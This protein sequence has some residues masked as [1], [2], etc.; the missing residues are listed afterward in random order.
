M[1]D[2]RPAGVPAGPRCVI[3]NPTAGGNRARL[4]RQTLG[5]LAGQPVLM[6]TQCAGDAR[7]LAAEAIASGYTTIVAAGGDGTVNEVVDGL[8]TLPERLHG[9]RFGILPLG[10][11]NVLALELGIPFDWAKAWQLILG[12]SERPIDV[13]RA[14]FSG[15]HGEV[16]RH[17]VQLAGAGWDAHAIELVRWKLK[18][19]IGPL[20]YVLAGSIALAHDNPRITAHTSE[21]SASGQLVLVGNGR[22]YAGRYPF[23]HRARYDDGLLDVCV[24]ER[25]DWLSLPGYGL[26]FLTGQLFCPGSYRYFQTPSVKLVCDQ[27][28]ALQLEG[29]FVGRVPAVLEVTPHQLRAAVP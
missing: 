10:T 24:F 27:P 22:F 16:T 19:M 5:T 20:A 8:M 14:S 11:I 12:G 18:K 23:F 15:E 21:G 6:P 17:F 9:I 25:F 28:A 1:K 7:R 26:K 4:L 2:H 3:F 13:A 29:D